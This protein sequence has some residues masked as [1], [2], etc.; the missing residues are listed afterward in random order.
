M[1]KNEALKIAIDCLRDA[2]R[3]PETGAPHLDEA[4]AVLEIERKKI[5]ELVVAFRELA[6]EM[7]G[8]S[9]A[10]ERS[11]YAARYEDEIQRVVDKLR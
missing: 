3:D 1:T 10:A 4:I 11:S 2:Y 7:F 9:W 5:T 6:S 8:D